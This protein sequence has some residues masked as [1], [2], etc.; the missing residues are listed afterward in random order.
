[1]ASHVRTTGAMVELVAEGTAG[2]KLRLIPH[3]SEAKAL[4]DAW[5]TA[6]GAKTTVASTQEDAGRDGYAQTSE[7]YKSVLLTFS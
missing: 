6:H 2:V 3:D 4:L 1:M 7:A 5:F